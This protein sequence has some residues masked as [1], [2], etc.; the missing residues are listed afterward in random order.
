[1]FLKPK[2]SDEQLVRRVLAGR[3]EDFGVLVRRHLAA[4]YAVAYARTG[5][6]AD[7]D[8]VAQET[9]LEA[10]KSLDTLRDPA[11]FGAWL[12]GIARHTANRSNRKRA[13][14]VNATAKAS[15]QEATDVPDMARRELRALVRTEVD[16]LDPD[17][18]EVLFL[19]YFAGKNAKEIAA[20]LDITHD[21]ARKRLERARESLGARLLAELGDENELAPLLSK[22]TKHIT[23]LAL[24]AMVPWKATAAAGRPGCMTSCR[25]A[26]G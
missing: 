6:H 15:Q 16:K 14:E 7:A 5:N 12:T 9:C 23:G 1:M 13:R 11:K 25:W 24:A 18:R 2:N 3:R 8:D 20:T 22:R 4:T 19:A 21:A 10:L 17:K 26:T